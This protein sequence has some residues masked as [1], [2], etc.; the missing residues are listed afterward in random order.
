MTREEAQELGRRAIYHATFRD[1]Y[2]G[3]TV[4]GKFTRLAALCFS[5]LDAA[6]RSVVV[7]RLHARIRQSWPFIG[8]PN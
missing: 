1:A 2:S 4:S 3:G 8:M 7:S 5:L 6:S